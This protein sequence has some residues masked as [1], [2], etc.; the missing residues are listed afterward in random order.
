M[1]PDEKVVLTKKT[2]KYIYDQYSDSNKDLK[3]QVIKYLEIF[4]K[5]L[6]GKKVIDIGCA[7]GNETDYLAKKGLEVVGYDISK[8]FINL[9]KKRYPKYKFTVKDMR[10]LKLPDNSINGIWASA[11]FLH[12]PKS[13]ALE[14]LVRFNTMLLR[15]GLLYVSV[16][17][18]DFDDI[19][20]NETMQ[21]PGRHFSDYTKT[22]LIYLLTKANF[23]VVDTYLNNTDWGPTFIHCFSVKQ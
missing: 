6:N 21:W 8:E 23:K 2:Y 15:G 12:I 17:E 3:P 22:E 19:R 11:S 9:A 4:T 1:N 14:T 18:G 13:F 5:K 7:M 10:S 20:E 16:M